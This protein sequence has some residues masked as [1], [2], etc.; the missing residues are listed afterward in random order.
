MCYSSYRLSPGSV[1]PLA[2]FQIYLFC[3]SDNILLYKRNLNRQLLPQIWIT[4][5]RCQSSDKLKFLFWEIR[6]IN[7]HTVD[8]W[9][10]LLFY[11]MLEGFISLLLQNLNHTW[12]WE[13]IW[14]RHMLCKYSST[15]I[16]CQKYSQS[17][18]SSRP[19]LSTKDINPSMWTT[20]KRHNSTNPSQ[21]CLI[22]D[23]IT[24]DNY[25]WRVPCNGIVSNL[26]PLDVPNLLSLFL[27]SCIRATKITG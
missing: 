3:S 27:S 14:Q 12:R 2:M 16:C 19:T 8:M 17:N 23:A 24:I 21:I 4:T 15:K 25:H 11:I 9:S 22:E 18:R 6:E 26:W 13:R 1:V 20:D 5:D 10:L 7:S